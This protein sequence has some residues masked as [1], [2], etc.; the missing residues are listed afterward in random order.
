[1]VAKELQGDRPHDFPIEAKSLETHIRRVAKRW[2]AEYAEA[3]ASTNALRP[4]LITREKQA[5]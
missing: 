3:L 4:F 1:M 5:D 2:E